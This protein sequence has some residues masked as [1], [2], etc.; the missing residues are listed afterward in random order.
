MQDLKREGP[1][2][3]DDK[4][5]NLEHGGTIHSTIQYTILDA[6]MNYHNE[7]YHKAVRLYSP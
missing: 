3:R 4:M 7:Y 1:N 5:Q 6:L 2:R